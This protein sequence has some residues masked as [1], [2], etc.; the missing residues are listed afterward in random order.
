MN[1]IITYGQGYKLSPGIKVFVKSA[2]QFCNTLTV[3]SSGLTSELTT[4]L[5]E[6]GVNIVN[7]DTLS[8]KF[9]IQTTLSPY[10]L[11]VIYFY[12]YAKHISLASNVYLCDFTDVLFQK[13]PFSL[14]Q[15][16]KP[17]VTS[18]NQY[19]ADCQTNATWINLC[20]NNDVFNLLK[21][22]Q[23]L[24]GGNI[25]GSRYS[26]TE[27]LKEMCTD[28]THI[29]SRIGNYQNI[30]QASLNKTVYF[31]QQRY[32]ILNNLEIVNL[33]HVSKTAKYSIS[34]SSIIINGTIPAVIHQYDFIKEIENYLYVKYQ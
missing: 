10:T 26:C 25:F 21:K 18:E 24:N 1:E 3:I 31:D 2:K 14:I 28:M 23:I 29:I 27:L 16:P 34:E 12:L 5:T 17:Y 13:T 11:K 7:A 4:F 20:Y 32:N 8:E 30:D 33:A 6:N 15:N 22:Y 9:N 19:I